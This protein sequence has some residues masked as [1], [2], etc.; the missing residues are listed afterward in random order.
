MSISN[1]IQIKAFLGKYYPALL[2]SS[3]EDKYSETYLS[4]FFDQR[5]YIQNNKTQMIIDPTLVGLSVVVNGNEIL[6]SKELFDHPNVVIT[7]SIESNDTKSR[8]LY[9]PE[10]FSSIAYLICQNST[11]FDV[12]GEID[13][14]IYIK[15]RS[16]LECFY[17]SV[18]LIK[19]ADNLGIEII[20]EIESLG[21][22][23][24][25]TNYV[26]APAAKLKLTTFYQNIL[27]AQS[28]MYRNIIAQDYSQYTHMQFG[29]GSS[30]IIDETRLHTYSNVKTELLGCIYPGNYNF[31]T[32]LALQP[33]M[34]NYDI[35][36]NHRL[37][38]SGVGTATFTPVSASETLADMDVTSFDVTDVPKAILI[39]KV[40]DFVAD[41]S[42]RAVLDRIS[43]SARFYANKTKFLSFQ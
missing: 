17:N 8:A 37:V 2:L 14:P 15:Y 34:D 4:S 1:L 21:A 27:S 31:H 29:H 30:N 43:G 41:V 28:F 3:K 10:I 16:E 13:E 40:N 23:N 5:F 24:S 42:D 36:V 7:N 32:I 33:V 9:N 22:L 25:V 26:L 12:V 20:E 19:I 35:R 38:L 39:Q 18:L 6:V 11:M